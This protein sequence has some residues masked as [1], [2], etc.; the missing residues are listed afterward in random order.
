MKYRMIAM[1]SLLT[2][3]MFATTAFAQPGPSDDPPEQ[4]DNRPGQTDNRSDSVGRISLIHG[5]VS[6]Q[7]GDSGDWAAATLNQPVVSGDKVSTG[8]DS[9]AEVQLDF[10][11][12]LRLGDQSQATIAGLTRN[13]IQVQLGNGLAYYSVFKN[14]EAQPEIDTPNVA[15]HPENREGVYRIEVR[16]GQTFVVVR[17]G[18][19]DISTP[20]GSTHVDKGQ[21]VT[22]R[23]TGDQTEYRVA[24]APS[25]DNW[26]SWNNDRNNLIQRA[27]AWGRTN[28]Y[29]VGS[30]DLD[31]YGRWVNVPDY[32]PV[33][34]PAVAPGWAPY[35]AGRWVWEP[36]YGWT[37]VSYEPWGWAPYHY[38]RWFVYNSAWVWWP[39]PVY[40]TPYYR[41]VWA[42]AYVSFFGFGGGVGVSVGFGFGSVGWLP[43]GPADPYYPWYGRYRNQFNTVNVTNITNVTN[44][45]NNNHF[46]PV[47]PLGRGYSNLNMVANNERIR[48]GVSMVPSNRFGT[49][50]ARPIAVSAETFRDG[51]VMTGNLPIVPSRETLSASDRPAAASTMRGGEP[52][53]FYGRTPTAQTGSFDRQASQLQQDIARSGHVTPVIAGNGN[54]NIQVA[55]TNVPFHGGETGTLQTPAR[56]PIATTNRTVQGPA[57]NPQNMRTPSPDRNT[58]DGFSRLGGG[59]AQNSNQNNQSSNKPSPSTPARQSAPEQTSRPTQSAPEQGGW[60]RF[61]QRGPSSTGNTPSNPGSNRTM[62]PTSPTRESMPSTREST[63]SSRPS[64]PATRESTP[65]NGGWQRF[66]SNNGPSSSRSESYP[67]SNSRGESYPGSTSRGESYPSPSNGGWNRT[68]S[69]DSGPSTYSRPSSGPSYSGESRSSRPPLDLRQPIVTPRSG[70]ESSGRYEGPSRSESRP[71]APSRGSEPSRPSGGSSHSSSGGQHSSSSNHR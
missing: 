2:V 67:S 33:W 29:Y 24:D 61:G 31:A 63:P 38:G 45:Y 21:S 49:G 6:T 65:S 30:E 32:G 5:D 53:K 64:M 34:T 68:P 36:Y 7:R 39:G 46:P 47:R 12:I 40:A 15:I 23:G 14:A 22:I 10:A 66:P 27:D 58:N 28:R 37:W 17:K 42:P 71:S 41:P 13:Q 4:S 1:L 51:R 35:R 11:N 55:K 57:N 48:D 3:A 70:Y 54:S 8:N 25:K 69:R 9:R 62:Q 16:D 26:D 52:Q 59:M 18:A 56:D 44:V 20:Q 43:I 60:T 50:T 19:L